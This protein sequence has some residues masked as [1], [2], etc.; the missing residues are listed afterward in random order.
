MRRHFP[1]KYAD[2]QQVYEKSDQY[3]DYQN[4]LLNGHEFEQTPGDS[5]GQGSLVRCSPW[6]SQRIRHNLVTEQ[7]NHKLSLRC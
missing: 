1:I 4:H 5:E 6:G 7:Q 2:D 3:P